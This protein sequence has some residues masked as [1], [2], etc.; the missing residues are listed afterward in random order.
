M[1][2]SQQTSHPE[3]QSSAK[4]RPRLASALGTP[5]LEF[6]AG[7]VNEDRA[8]TTFPGIT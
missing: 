1:R 8:S 5:R 4:Q 2:I 6:E 3:A 7:L